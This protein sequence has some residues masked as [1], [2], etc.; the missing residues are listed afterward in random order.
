MKKI[1]I[2]VAAAALFASCCQTEKTTLDIVPYPNNVELKCGS[3]T[4]AG[5][6]FHLDPAMDE[7]SKAIVNAF[8]EQLALTS[9]TTCTVTEGAGKNGF[10]FTV[11]TGMPAEGFRT[12][13]IQLCHT[14]HQ[15]DAPC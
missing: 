8:A 9:G 7:A 10:S 11:D 13:R 3:F 14:D 12:E 6:E 15:A 1:F 4:A 2:L 5:A